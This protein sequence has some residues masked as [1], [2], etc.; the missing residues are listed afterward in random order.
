MFFW[1]VWNDRNNEAYMEFPYPFY[2][3]LRADLLYDLCF[4]FGAGGHFKAADME[5]KV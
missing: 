1:R 4:P 3:N 5:R 2:L